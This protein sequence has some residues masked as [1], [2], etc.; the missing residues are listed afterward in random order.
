MNEGCSIVNNTANKMQ[1]QPIQPAVTITTTFT[2]RRCS[3]GSSQMGRYVHRLR[4]TFWPFFTI[5][6]F[7]YDFQPFVLVVLVPV[8]LIFKD[9]PHKPVSH[10]QFWWWVHFALNFVTVWVSDNALVYGELV[11]IRKRCLFY[12]LIGPFD[13]WLLWSVG[14]IAALFSIIFGSLYLSLSRSSVLLGK[15]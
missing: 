12:P 11:S 15:D 4:F 5:K 10:V 14:A 3:S 13:S 9:R 6:F 8:Y 7:L 2:V 1:R